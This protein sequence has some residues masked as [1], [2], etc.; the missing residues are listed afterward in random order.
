MNRLGL[1]QVNGTI[2]FV[3]DAEGKVRGVRSESLSA[4]E[5]RYEAVAWF[6]DSLRSPDCVIDATLRERVVTIP[7]QFELTRW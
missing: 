5:L 7:F 4:P 2:A 3:V 1:R 6:S